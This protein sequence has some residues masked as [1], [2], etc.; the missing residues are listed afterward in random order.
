LKPGGAYV[1]QTPHLL[2]GPTDL[3]RIFGLKQPVCMHLKEYD[4]TTLE[5]LLLASGFT[6]IE[7]IYV[8]PRRVR[9][10]ARITVPSAT[11]LRLCKRAEAA[12]LPSRLNRW[13]INILTGKNILIRAVR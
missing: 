5:R 6:T 9:R 7:A 12:R 4:Y 8:P 2:S 3:S 13:C 1:F 10:F 11:F